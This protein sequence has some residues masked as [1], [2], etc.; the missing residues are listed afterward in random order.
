VAGKKRAI[1]PLDKMLEEEL[2]K[3]K[4]GKLEQEERDQRLQIL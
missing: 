3:I 4:L 1:E 2:N